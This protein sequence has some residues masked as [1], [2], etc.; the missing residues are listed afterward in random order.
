MYFASSRN[1]GM[2]EYS[3]VFACGLFSLTSIRNLG[4]Y[5]GAN[6]TN[7]CIVLSEYPDLFWPKADHATWAVPVFPAR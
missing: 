2:A 4:L 3:A 6:P 7:D 5:A 1:R